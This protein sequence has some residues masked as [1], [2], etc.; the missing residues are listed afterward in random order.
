MGKMRKSISVSNI[1]NVETSKGSGAEKRCCLC[2]MVN[3]IV[4]RPT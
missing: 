1:A 4:L 2:E 3:K